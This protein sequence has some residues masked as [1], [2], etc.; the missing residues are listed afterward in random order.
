MAE[1]LL[2]PRLGEGVTELFVSDW[3]KNEGDTVEEMEPVVEVETDKVAT[4]LPS[5]AAGVILKIMAAKGSTVQVGEVMAYIGEPGESLENLSSPEVVEADESKENDENEQNKEAPAEMVSEMEKPATRLS[6]LVKKIAAQH[7]ID[8]NDVK[9]TG[10][11]G[12]IT[13]D[14]VLSFL[15]KKFRVEKPEQDTKVDKLVVEPA[16]KEKGDKKQGSGKLVPHSSMRRR[17][18]DNMVK[19]IQSTPH[20]LTVMEADLTSVLSHKK[21]NQAAF[22][23]KGIRLTLTAYFIAAIVEALKAYPMANSSWTDEGVLVHKSIN[24]GMAV[25]LGENGLIVPVIKNAASLSLMGIAQQVNDLAQRARAKKLTVDEVK[26]VTFSLTNHGSGGSLFATPIINEPQSGIL[27]TGVLQKRPVV[28]SDAQGNDAIAIRPMIYLS[29]VFDH[30]VLD[31]E[32]A[33]K[34][35]SIVKEKLEHDTVSNFHRIRNRH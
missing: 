12:R 9:G 24:L 6:P 3:L 23:E 32:G 31:G 10:A 7:N 19:A 17:I 33:D 26:D 13:K 1:K 34:F 35:L 30:R 5:P 4:E 2:A 14:D 8:L 28:I 20:V 25:A 18:A 15:D 29:Y 27:G 16:V 22:A 21:A 11:G